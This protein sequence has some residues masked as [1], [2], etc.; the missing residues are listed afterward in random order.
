MVESL[1]CFQW[2]EY[3]LILYFKD[4]LR[5]SSIGWKFFKFLIL[6][7]QIKWASLLT[8]A[9]IFYPNYHVHKYQQEQN[10][11]FLDYSDFY[12]L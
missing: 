2:G 9:T 5:F 1:A 10:R 4:F 3:D 11:T 6:F 7:I 12:K 8:S